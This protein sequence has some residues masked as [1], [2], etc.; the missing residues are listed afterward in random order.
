MRAQHV[1]HGCRDLQATITTRCCLDCMLQLPD[2]PMQC[3]HRVDRC[4]PT[5]ASVHES[6]RPRCITRMASALAN[7]RA[8]LPTCLFLSGPTAPMLTSS[9]YAHGSSVPPK[10]MGLS[11]T[12]LQRTHCMGCHRTEFGMGSPKQK[13]LGFTCNF[14]DERTQGFGTQSQV[15]AA[16]RILTCSGFP[17]L[18]ATASDNALSTSELPT[19]FPGTVK[20][21]ARRNNEWEC[22]TVSNTVATAGRHSFVTLCIHFTVSADVQGRHGPVLQWLLRS[23][24][25][26]NAAR[27]TKMSSL[28]FTLQRMQCNLSRWQAALCSLKGLPSFAKQ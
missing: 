28:T 26:P 15:P 13:Q 18:L 12:K 27:R 6:L 14:A 8:A 24:Q 9:A 7:K 19:R 17:T 2:R 10:I 5:G 11:V 23:F 1:C 21:A 20:P 16:G 22:A 4:R 25:F 3:M